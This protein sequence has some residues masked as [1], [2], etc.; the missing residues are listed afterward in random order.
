MVDGCAIRADFSVFKKKIRDD[1]TGFQVR[2]LLAAQ[3]ASSGKDP[4]S[5]I[6]WC[7]QVKATKDTDF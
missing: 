2:H 3:P 5:Q 6:T 4:Q 1:T 7:L